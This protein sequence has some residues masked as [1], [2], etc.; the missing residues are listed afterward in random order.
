MQQ[1]LDSLKEHLVQPLCDAILCGCIMYG[2]FILS[3]HSLQVQF[4]TQIFST[5]VHVQLPDACIHLHLAPHLILLVGSENFTLLAQQIKVSEASKV[6][7]ECQII[8][9]VLQ[10]L[11]WGWAPH[12]TVDLLTECLCMVLRIVLLWYRL[13]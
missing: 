4:I 3:S 13:V 2:E 12:I 1:G 10:R 8:S 9:V 6:I 11:D 7:S 5:M